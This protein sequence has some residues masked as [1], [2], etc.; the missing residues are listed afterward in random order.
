MVGCTWS[1]KLKS[2][3]VISETAERV[4]MTR[5]SPASPSQ[6]RKSISAPTGSPTFT[7]PKSPMT[8]TGSW[9][10]EDFGASSADRKENTEL[11]KKEKIIEGLQR[12]L[13]DRDSQ[14]VELRLMGDRSGVLI[15]ELQLSLKRA[16]ENMER[17][18][19]E[20]AVS[21]MANTSD[22]E[23]KH[24]GKAHPGECEDGTDGDKPV[25]ALRET[26]SNESDLEIEMNSTSRSSNSRDTAE[27]NDEL[28]SSQS[29]TSSSGTTASAGLSAFES[30]PEKK[31]VTVGSAPKLT[32]P[33]KNGGKIPARCSDETSKSGLP[34]AAFDF[35]LWIVNGKIPD[36]RYISKDQR[37]SLFKGPTVLVCVGKE[38]IPN[39]PKHMFMAVSSKAREHFLNCPADSFFDVADNNIDPADVKDIVAWFTAI[40]TCKGDTYSLKIQPNH[41]HNVKLRYA[42]IV[43]GMEGYV[44]HIT[45][46]LCD[47]VR[48]GAVPISLVRSIVHFTSDNDSLMKCLVNNLAHAQVK[49]KLSAHPKLA[50]FVSSN[51]QFSDAAQ[52]IASGM[53]PKRAV[54]RGRNESFPDK[55]G[56]EAFRSA[57]AKS[58]SPS[59]KRTKALVSPKSTPRHIAH[60]VQ[61][62]SAREAAKL[63]RRSA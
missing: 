6:A 41:E 42:A 52:R 61:V 14:I 55:A 36:V 43:L 21:W 18:Q 3:T 5:L 20:F 34:S 13:K 28:V 35:G 37:A 63:P 58:A 26:D 54:S 27:I 15:Q 62:L 4:Q 51:P 56:K 10:H 30:R 16:N 45:K 53:M 24:N 44:R 46:H 9:V 47:Q 57:S 12:A 33:I 19:Y 11:D 40:G 8:T 32:F 22:V 29:C 39:V 25:P 50:A 7:K 31:I 59:K 17:L 1:D 48:E 23:V 38:K 60:G 49:G 2:S